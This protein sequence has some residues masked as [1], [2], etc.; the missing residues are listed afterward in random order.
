[1]S[2]NLNELEDYFWDNNKAFILYQIKA[3]ILN[4]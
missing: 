2:L 3:D 4:E 1:M